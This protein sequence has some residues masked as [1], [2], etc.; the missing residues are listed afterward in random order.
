MV[1]IE[2]KMIEL[3]TVFSRYWAF[4]TSEMELMTLYEQKTKQNIHLYL[5]H[6][7]TC[8]LYVCVCMC[9]SV[10]KFQLYSTFLLEQHQLT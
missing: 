10:C 3:V 2:T 9:V 4:S 5:Q 6:A 1:T 7:G 8:Q